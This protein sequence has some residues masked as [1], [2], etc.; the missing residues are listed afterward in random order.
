M[1]CMLK[2]HPGKAEEI[3]QSCRRQISDQILRDIF[4]FTYDRMKRYEGSWH[5][6]KMQLFPDCIFVETADPSTLVGQLES[7][8]EFLHISEDRKILWPLS[9]EE[10]TFLR[11]LG[12]SEHHLGMSQGYIH[13]GITHII[14]GPLVG[15]ERRIRKIDRHKRTANVA[16]PAGGL[17][18]FLLA[19]LEITSK[20]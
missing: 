1:W 10:E 17:G 5:V 20:S 12:G 16:M 14:H 8:R 18:P 7:Y 3:L 19:G 4:V 15:M 11:E 6:E 2:C 9:P 13:N